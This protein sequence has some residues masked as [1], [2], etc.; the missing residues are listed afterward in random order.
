MVAGHACPL[1]IEVRSDDGG[2]SRTVTASA[3]LEVR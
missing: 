2:S 1:V 3:T